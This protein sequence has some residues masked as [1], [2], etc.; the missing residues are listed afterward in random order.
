MSIVCLFFRSSPGAFF[1]FPVLI[2]SIVHAFP[3]C[4]SNRPSFFYGHFNSYIISDS[5]LISK[6]DFV[7]KD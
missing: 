5:L 4:M 3:P 6:P 2:F 1:W 7:K